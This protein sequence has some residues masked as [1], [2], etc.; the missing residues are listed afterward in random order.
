MALSQRESLSV[1]L[2]TVTCGWVVDNTNLFL[3]FTRD[4]STKPPKTPL[5]IDTL[6]L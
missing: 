2:V 6:V 4:P 5:S 3:R 1:E